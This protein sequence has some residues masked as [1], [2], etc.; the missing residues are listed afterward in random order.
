MS[1]VE[2]MVSWILGGGASLVILS[3]LGLWRSK[4]WGWWLALLMDVL[5]LAA[6][7]W[8][9]VERHVWPDVDELSFIILFVVLI[10]LLFLA[11]VR[12]FFL[13]RKQESVEAGA[14]C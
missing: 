5:G 7:L 9:S 13:R 14:G 6:F 12:R 3:C 2:V 1:A 10:A 8:D 11:P 4:A